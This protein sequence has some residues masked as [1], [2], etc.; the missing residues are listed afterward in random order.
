[1]GIHTDAD[2]ASS[3]GGGAALYCAARLLSQSPARSGS[4]HVPD[5]GM[6][7]DVFEVSRPSTGG[8][9]LA[10][11][12]ELIPPTLGR[13][14]CSP[15]STR[16]WSSTSPHLGQLIGLGAGE[17][18]ADGAVG[19]LVGA[20]IP[21][22]LLI[23]ALP[24]LI[25]DLCDTIQNGRTAGGR[26]HSGSPRKQQQQQQQQEAVSARGQGQGSVRKLSPMCTAPTGRAVTL[27]RDIPSPSDRHRAALRGL[28]TATEQ[29]SGDHRHT[30]ELQ[31]VRVHACMH[32]C[33]T[34]RT[35]AA[36]GESLPSCAV[37]TCG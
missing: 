31:Q 21:P 25:S 12:V 28:S 32:A 16:G 37:P 17:L 2:G 22:A 4:F 19:P 35:C 11:L 15:P 1:M 23:Q 34:C 13:P 5:Q 6:R 3:P 14:H 33:T 9:F 8:A 30:L 27:T 18:L 20:L 29:P 24:Q 26:A 7:S 36:R 10:N